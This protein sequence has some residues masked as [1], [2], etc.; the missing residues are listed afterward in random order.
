MEI[1]QQN[2][3]YSW[4]TELLA[5]CPSGL[6]QNRLIDFAGA[7]RI[8]AQLNLSTITLVPISPEN[9]DGKRFYDSNTKSIHM[10]NPDCASVV[11]H[12][13]AHAM[14]WHLFDECLVGCESVDFHHG[15]DFMAI[16]CLLLGN[17]YRAQ[18]YDEWFFATWAAQHDIAV[19]NPE[20]FQSL[21]TQN[22]LT[23]NVLQVGNDS[24][25]PV[26]AG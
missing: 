9:F 21:L 3:I 2:K 4:L 11:L 5:F 14:H 19:D 23:N 26:F 6:E 10:P 20:R 17:Y 8:L 7:A 13:I 25:E 1:R 15:P 16:W 22:T 24:N 12:E 18:G